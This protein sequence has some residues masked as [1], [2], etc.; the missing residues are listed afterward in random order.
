MNLQTLLNPWVLSLGAG[1]VLGAG[2]LFLLVKYGIAWLVGDRQAAASA[3]AGAQLPPAVT[4]APRRTLTGLSWTIATTHRSTSQLIGLVMSVASLVAIV[5]SVVAA[6]AG[7]TIIS[8]QK[9]NNVFFS[10][11]AAFSTLILSMLIESI[12]INALKNIRLSNEAIEQAEQAH[13]AQIVE[14]MEEQ[15]EEDSQAFAQMNQKTLTKEEMASMKRAASLKQR[16]RKEFEKKRHGL[17]KQQTRN[18]RHTRN[19]S[20][21]LAAAGVLFSAT[22]GGLFWHTVLIALDLWLNITIGT[23]FA[24]VV[25]VTFVQ[26]ELLKRIKDDAVKESLQSGEMQSTMLRQ[27]SEEMVLEMVVDSMA[28]TKEDPNTLQEMGDA[29]KGELKTAIRTLTAQTTSRLVEGSEN[30]VVVVSEVPETVPQIE[31][32]AVSKRQKKEPEWLS[33][34]ALSMVLKMYPK[35]NEK[36]DSWRS[37]SRVSVSILSLINATGHSRRVI[38]NRIKDGTVKV[39]PNNTN[40]V[41][42]NSVIDWLN[43]V[44]VPASKNATAAQNDPVTETIPAAIDPELPEVSV[45]QADSLPSEADKDW[46]E[47]LSSVLEVLR[48]NPDITDKELAAVLSLETLEIAKFWRV[49]AGLMLQRGQQSVGSRS[50]GHVGHEKEVDLLDFPS[51]LV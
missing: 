3:Q 36:V 27:Q 9:F 47:K 26:S 44:E 13:Y 40:L 34:P 37:A 42:I 15:F 23:M 2:L 38:Q 6:V 50:N 46:E 39:S 11:I 32:K 24:L 18:A 5:L 19:S 48:A 25:S 8:Y 17:M 33:N 16:A 35:L 30:P 43:D 20:I 1:L 7:V 49:N 22:A 14:Q 29:I 10:V 51:I 12:S 41:L 45:Q 21:P 4:T 28:A 31:E